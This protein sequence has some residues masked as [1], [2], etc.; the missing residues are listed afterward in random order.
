MLHIAVYGDSKW[1]I[2]MKELLEN[3]YSNMVIA[4]GGEGLAVD[5]LVSLSPN[6]TENQISVADFAGRYLAGELV[7]IIIPK[8]YY[9]QQNGIILALLRNGV[10]ID[11]IYS[12]IRLSDKVRNNPDAIAALITPYLEDSYLSYLEFHVADHCNLNCK[13]CTHY[14]PLVKEPV[15][16]DYAEF[17]RG[18]RQLKKYVYDIGVI[19]IL[20]GE[21]LLN[22]ELDKFIRLVRS[23]YPA[24]IIDVV[25]NGLLVEKISEELIETMREC[26]AFFHISLYKPMQD[27]IKQVEKFLYEK[28]IAYSLSPLNSVFFKTQTLERQEEEDF[29]YSC[30]QATC[31]CLQDGKLAPCYAPFTTKYFNHEFHQNIPTDEGVDLFD[32]ELNL[33]LLKAQMLIPMERCHYCYNGVPHEWSVVGRNSRLEDWV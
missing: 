21:P 4:N 19:R 27:K 3:E 23:L 12:G 32:T 30:F 9:I 5:Y 28:G 29:F 8:E 24:A 7:A 26:V 31:T 33:P 13:F 6:D 22:P 10:E 14:S 17:E 20:G 18:I 2:L 15:F 1:S 25:T 11:S 16:T